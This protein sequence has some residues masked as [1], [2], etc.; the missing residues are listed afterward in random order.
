MLKMTPNLGMGLDEVSQL[1]TII[2]KLNISELGI[3]HH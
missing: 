3:R 1:A 2:R